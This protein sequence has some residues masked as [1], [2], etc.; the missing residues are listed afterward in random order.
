MVRAFSTVELRSLKVSANASTVR[1]YSRRSTA[2]AG[3]ASG[4]P[5][6]PRFDSFASVEDA[7]SLIGLVSHFDRGMAGKNRHR[8]VDL[9][10]RNREDE[11]HRSLPTTR[12][13]HWFVSVVANASLGRERV[14]VTFASAFGVAGIVLCLGATEAVGQV[15]KIEWTP[16]QLASG[17]RSYFTVAPTTDPTL[18]FGTD[19]DEVGLVDFN[20]APDGPLVEGGDVTTQYASLGVTMNGIRISASIYGGNLYGPGF[21]TEENNPQIYTFAKPVKAVGIINTSPDKDLIQFFSGPDAT[22]TL[23]LA[24]NDQEG[25]PMNFDIDRF[26]GGVADE[27]VTIRSFV[28]SNQSGDLEL[29]ELIFAWADEPTCAAD[30]NSDGVV[31]AADLAMLLGAWGGARLGDLDGSGI[32]GAADL[33]VLLGAWGPC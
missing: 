26:V 2:R 21:A 33:A 29:D 23:L 6:R 13:G 10:A 14:M 11:D 17:N 24:F 22:G 27:G 25:L 16:T 1:S 8:G 30:L 31:D 19:F 5:D 32:V 18:F 28:V 9:A 12:R 3:S 15:T 20:S 4:A 7:A